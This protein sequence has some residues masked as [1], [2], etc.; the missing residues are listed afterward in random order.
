M[1]PGSIRVGKKNSDEQQVTSDEQE[2]VLRSSLA[3]RHLS[4]F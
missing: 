2:I 1:P 3:A 4:L